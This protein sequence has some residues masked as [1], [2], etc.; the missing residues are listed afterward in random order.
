[1]DTIGHHSSIL[2]L[3][4]AIIGSRKVC[5]L[6][7][8]ALSLILISML[9]IKVIRNQMTVAGTITGRHFNVQDLRSGLKFLNSNDFQGASLISQDCFFFQSR[10]ASISQTRDS[11]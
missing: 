6:T 3:V 5:S 7:L 1:M 10:N 8:T 9:P 2:H 11:S 4:K